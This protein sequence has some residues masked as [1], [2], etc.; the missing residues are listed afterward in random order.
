MNAEHAYIEGFVKRA[1][2]Y[3]VNNR[4]AIK[5]LKQASPFT[6]YV[7]RDMTG[8]LLGNGVAVLGGMATNGLNSQLPTIT[9]EQNA[10][11]RQKLN[12]PDSVK[13]NLSQ[14]SKHPLSLGNNA[15]F[16]PNSNQVETFSSNMNT[17]PVIAHEYGHANIHHGNNGPVKFLQDNVYPITPF[18][19]APT[20]AIADRLLKNETSAGKGAL[21]G[22]GAQAV[23]NAGRIIPEFEASRRGLGVINEGASMKDKIK[24][25]AT[26]APGFASYL[27]PVAGGAVRGAMRA[28][29]NQKNQQQPNIPGK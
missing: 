8:S 3:G 26:L 15:Q 24:N 13:Q 21:I 10:Q 17:A 25:T 20:N 12:I 9:D 22:A 2:E 5:L 27:A 29:Q 14:N 28:N 18:A 23:A 1:A 7:K 16:D 6:D 11:I 4:D 19:V